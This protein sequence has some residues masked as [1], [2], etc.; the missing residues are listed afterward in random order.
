M[1]SSGR[2]RFPLALPPRLIV[3]NAVKVATTMRPLFH[4]TYIYDECF[5]VLV[6]GWPIIIRY[7]ALAAYTFD[8]AGGQQHNIYGTPR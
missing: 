6:T 8:S 2:T 7:W 3:H 4:A 1:G 5:Y